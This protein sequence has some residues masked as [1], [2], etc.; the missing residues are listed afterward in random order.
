MPYFCHQC[1]RGVEAEAD[2]DLRCSRCHSEF[3]EEI[4]PGEHMESDEGQEESDSESETDDLLQMLV[5]T[6]RA[7]RTAPNPTVSRQNAPGGPSSSRQHPSGDI[8]ATLSALLPMVGL[9]SQVVS[10][11]TTG[12]PRNNPQPNDMPNRTEFMNQ[13]LTNALAGSHFQIQVNGQPIHGDINNY[14]FGDGTFD[15][16][17]SQ[18]LNNGEPQ[19]QGLTQEDLKCLEKTIIEKEQVDNGIQCTTC[20]ETLNLGE[21]V[22]KLDCKHV[23]HQ[24]CIFPWL[25]KSPTCPICRQEIE[26]KGEKQ[27]TVIPDIIQLD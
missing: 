23:F 5:D 26:S 17:V 20:M 12:Q 21:E 16:L 19:Q 25:V 11:R 13:L 9:L 18:L 22:I 3:I 1:Q 2:Q 7:R 24:D 15:Q 10:S 6:I 8:G 4:V 14:A 27:P